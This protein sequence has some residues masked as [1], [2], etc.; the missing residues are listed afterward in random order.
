[1]R[2]RCH[3]C[4]VILLSTDAPGWDL[5]SVSQ[6]GV[7]LARLVEQCSPAG[8]C[9]TSWRSPRL[10]QGPRIYP[11]SK[12]CTKTGLDLE[13][14]KGTLKEFKEWP[15]APW[16]LLAGYFERRLGHAF[17]PA[18]PRVPFHLCISGLAGR[19]VFTWKPLQC[20]ERALPGW[21]LQRPLIWW[22]S[23]WLIG[24][25]DGGGHS[26][27]ATL[28]RWKERWSIWAHGEHGD[29]DDSAGSSV[30][31]ICWELWGANLSFIFLSGKVDYR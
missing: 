5:E 15:H 4:C 1:M 24:T 19:E 20:W 6:T 27:E 3:C 26:Q 25:S 14:M 23:W 11:S 17:P 13:Q 2:M 31:G 9:G 30:L 8:V 16:G 29:G 18:S 7:L 10:E 28:I 22:C 21:G 12:P